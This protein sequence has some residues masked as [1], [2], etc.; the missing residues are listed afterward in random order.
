M[1]AGGHEKE[2]SLCKLNTENN[3]DYDDDYDDNNSSNIY[4]S[5][6]KN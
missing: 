4:C 3:N 6:N 2:R 1:R 5:V